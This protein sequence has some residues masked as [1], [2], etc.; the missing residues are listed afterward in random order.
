V[1][2]GTKQKSESGSLKRKM[3]VEDARCELCGTREEMTDSYHLW[4]SPQ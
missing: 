4:L 2:V 1:V 3:I